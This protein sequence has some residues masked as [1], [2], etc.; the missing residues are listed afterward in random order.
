VTIPGWESELDDP[1]ETPRSARST[2][3]IIHSRGA[4]R[5]EEVIFPYFKGKTLADY[6]L[7]RLD[8]DLKEHSF[9]GLLPA[10]ISLRWPTGK[11][12]AISATRWPTRKV[13]HKGL[14]GIK[15][16]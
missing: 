14:K 10:R 13:L 3:N 2:A 9:A 16:E 6:N 7:A 15:A 1:Y 5:A 11:W 4:E 12:A 8:D